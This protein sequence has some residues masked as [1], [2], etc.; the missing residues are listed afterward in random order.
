MGAAE[1]GCT[2]RPVLRLYISVKK[3]CSF[4]MS[5]L[6]ELSDA[7]RLARQLKQELNEVAQIST[8]IIEGLNTMSEKGDQAKAL[9]TEIG[10]DLQSVL[11]KLAGFTDGLTATETQEII[12]MLTPIAAKVPTPEA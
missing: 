11:D 8:T 6:S 7:V 1:S 9:I 3:G 2:L 5:I 10:T 12:D 4:I